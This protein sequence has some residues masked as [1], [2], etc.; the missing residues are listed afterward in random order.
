L[1]VVRDRVAPLLA[2]W[3]IEARVVRQDDHWR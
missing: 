3:G 2:G 1:V